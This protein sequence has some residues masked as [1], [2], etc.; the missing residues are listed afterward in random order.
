VCCQRRLGS[1]RKWTSCAWSDKL[2]EAMVPTCA[3][4]AWDILVILQV[5]RYHHLLFFGTFVNGG[6]NISL[7]EYLMQVKGFNVYDHGLEHH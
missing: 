1:K 3:R 6:K 7:H 5:V 4:S 2:A